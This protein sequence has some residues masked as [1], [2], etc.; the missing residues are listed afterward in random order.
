MSKIAEDFV[1]KFHIG[2]AV[3]KFRAIPKSSTEQALISTLHYLSRETHGTSAAVRLVLFD[4]R[5]A[6][7]LIDHY[8][9]VQK[10]TSLDIPYWV[11]NW[12]TDFLTDRNQR[13]KFSRTCFSV[14]FRVLQGTKLGPC[15]WLYLL[16]IN[17]LKA[18]N[19]PIWKYVDD[20]SIAETVPKGALSNA[21]AAVTSVENWS[22][23]NRMKLHP[24]KCKE[25][26]YGSMLWSVAL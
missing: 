8:L 22:R 6:F 11:K 26:L 14:P 7:D 25:L 1:I 21:Q 2:P 4:Y 20:T 10:L 16:M 3:L 17:D 23:E 15:P 24:G 19:V 18:P 12:V 9:L 5:K 13:I